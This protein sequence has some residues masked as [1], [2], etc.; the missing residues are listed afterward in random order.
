MEK[1]IFFSLPLLLLSF[2]ISEGCADSTNNQ[3]SVRF[4]TVQ[5]IDK[6]GIGIEAFRMLIPSDWKFEGGIRWINFDNP[7]MPAVSMF[8]ISNPNGSEELEVFPNQMF[9]WTNNPLTFSL[10]PV[11]SRYF[12]A[13]VRQP[14]DPLSFI[15]NTIIPRSRTN[16]SGIRVI[17]RQPLPELTKQ[18][19]TGQQQ[20]GI[21]VS[22]DAGKVKIE[23]QKDG[24]WFE[25]V[26][27][28]V[29]ES[30]SFPIQSMYGPVT[31]TNW[32][33]DYLFSFKAEKGKLDAS[34]KTFQTMVNS[35]QINPQWF[36]K[37]TQLT[38][39]LIQ[40]Q[41]KRINAIGEISRII[42]KT[43]NE[44]SDMMMETYT[45]RQNAYDRISENFSQTIRGVDPYYDPIEQKTVELP[46]GYDNAWTNSRGEYIL[47]DDPNFNPNVESNLNWQPMKINK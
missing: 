17:E 24:K 36:N 37:Y 6:D 21:T 16:V 39:Y 31:N 46:S 33:G 29:I 28:A 26:I 12:G 25:E 2:L 23:Y 27:F 10:F 14:T 20:Y 22:A 7:A 32:L 42:S 15:Q 30:V 13:E 11:G 18:F 35:F 41:I 40:N 44:I 3:S 9:F 5:Y 34:T 45:N 1:A 43:S 8:K 4:K 19:D 47:A 38:T